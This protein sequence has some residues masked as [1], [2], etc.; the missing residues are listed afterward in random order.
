MGGMQMTQHQQQQLLIPEQQYLEAR[1][2]AIEDV[3]SHIVEL[4]CVG[5]ALVYGVYICRVCMHG[6]FGGGGFGGSEMDGID[7][8]VHPYPPISYVYIPQPQQS[9]T[10]NPS[11]KQNVDLQQQTTTTPQPH[12]HT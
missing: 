11:K 12:T 5:V 4:G 1:A 8:S 10:Q 7:P 9:H 6:G 3:E 2:Q